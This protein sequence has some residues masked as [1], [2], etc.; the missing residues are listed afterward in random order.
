MQTKDV[1]YAY[2]PVYIAK[3]PERFRKQLP[4]KFRFISEKTYLQI[5]KRGNRE[6]TAK[7]CWDRYRCFWYNKEKMEPDNKPYNII[8]HYHNIGDE[9]CESFI[10]IETMYNVK[11]KQ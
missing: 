5:I 3:I 8:P 2:S 11:L 9:E 10:D 6:C 7:G 1:I 4:D